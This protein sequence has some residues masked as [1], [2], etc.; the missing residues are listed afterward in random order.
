MSRPT[1]LRLD[2][3]L[4]FA[5]YAAANTVTRAYRPLLEQIGLTYPQYLVMLVLWQNGECAVNEIASRL[6]LPPHAISPLVDRLSDAGLVVRRREAP[7]R[8]VVHV[9]LTA[10]GADLETAASEAQQ[11]VVCRTR[12]TAP[13]MTD[14][15]D[16]LHGLVRLMG[17]GPG[18]QSRNRRRGQDENLRPKTSGPARGAEPKTMPITTEGEAS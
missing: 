11:T 15:R 1:N 9:H 7:D 17:V 3:Q 18:V 16:D 13:A 5:L 8:R 10:A 12:L 14:L 2:D 4:C 6:A